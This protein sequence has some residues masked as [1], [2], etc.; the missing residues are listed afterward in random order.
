MWIWVYPSKGLNNAF[1]KTTLVTAGTIH[2][3]WGRWSK[4]YFWCSPTNLLWSY[5][6]KGPDPRRQHDGRETCWCYW[7]DDGIC[8]VKTLSNNIGIPWVDWC[9]DS[10]INKGT[11][12]CTWQRQRSRNTEHVRKLI[13]HLL[14]GGSNDRLSRNTLPNLINGTYVEQH[15]SW[16]PR[17][18]ALQHLILPHIRNAQPFVMQVNLHGAKLFKTHR[19]LTGSKWKS[20]WKHRWLTVHVTCLNWVE[21]WTGY[22]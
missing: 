6:N 12:E 22:L 5:R 3:C 7:V 20:D 21:L 1:D 16:N 13:N 8:V 14:N 15:S 2:V 9:V 11:P 17:R 18:Q 19:R 4:D 10:R